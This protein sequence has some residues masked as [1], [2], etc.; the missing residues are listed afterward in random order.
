LEVNVEFKRPIVILLAAF[1]IVATPT[2]AAEIQ[3][4]V[5]DSNGEA[6]RLANVIVLRYGSPGGV[7]AESATVAQLNEDGSFELSSLEPGRY[8]VTVTQYGHT[9][10]STSSFGLSSDEVA[11]LDVR[12]EQGGERQPIYFLEPTKNDLLGYEDRLKEFG[13]PGFC[14]QA[15]TSNDQ[16]TYRF[17]WQR[18]FHNPVL[19]RIAI[20]PD[21]SATATYKE[22]DRDR[23]SGGQLIENS[24]IDA[25]QYLVDT[26][27]SE[28]AATD[29][30]EWLRTDAESAFWEFPYW[31]DW[32]II[33]TDGA[34]WTMEGIRDGN[35][36][37]VTR[38]SPDRGNRFYQFAL[39]IM[40]LTGKR[41]YYDEVY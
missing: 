31:I 32:D 26:W 28:F 15:E 24:T 4:Q 33:T 12:L 1:G 3:G 29:H 8:S 7:T 37:V 2:D 25:H 6:T 11:T 22:L 40:N 10:W 30:I 41:L 20:D 38:V 34:V 21:N 14:S 23:E 36:H 5:L 13:E 18:S 9:P 17:L 39:Q 27:E 35:C 16:V 19:V